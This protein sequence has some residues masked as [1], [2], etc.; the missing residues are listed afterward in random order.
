[1]TLFGD[2]LSATKK[3]QEETYGF[4]FSQFATDGDPDKIKNLIKYLDMQYM[5]GIDEFSEF[6][7]EISWKSW[8][9]DGPYVHRREAIKELVDVLHFVANALVAMDCSTDELNEFYLGKMQVNR[10]RQE[11]KNGYRVTETGVKCRVCKRGL[12]DVLPS[13]IDET[14]CRMCALKEANDA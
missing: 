4:D 8:Q 2:W 11:R 14:M 6:H 7:N 5:A 10:H 9:S 12:D 3:L 1:M 13:S